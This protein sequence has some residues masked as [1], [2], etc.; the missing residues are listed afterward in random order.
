MNDQ[1]G[2]V[3]DERKTVNDCIKAI[4]DTVSPFGL[5]PFFSKL[6]DKDNTIFKE[7]RPRDYKEG[8]HF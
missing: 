4:I 5:K 2:A 8:G 6:D 7:H 1:I 3:R